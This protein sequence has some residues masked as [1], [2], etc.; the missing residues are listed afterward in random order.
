MQELNYSVPEFCK[1]AKISRAFLYTLWEKGE[2]PKKIKL[3]SRTLIR[4]NDAT[5]WLESLHDGA[6]Q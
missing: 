2:G 3:G 6:L 4:C 5:E 1:A